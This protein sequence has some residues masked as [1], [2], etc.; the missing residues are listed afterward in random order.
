MHLPLKSST[1]KQKS[2]FEL[3]EDSFSFLFFFFFLEDLSIFFSLFLLGSLRL[4]GHKGRENDLSLSLSIFSSFKCQSLLMT[5]SIQPHYNIAMGQSSLQLVILV[6]AKFSKYPLFWG[7]LAGHSWSTIV[8]LLWPLITHL[9]QL[10]LMPNC[11]LTS[12]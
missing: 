6:L 7:S 10:R 11:P 3:Q 5:T 9:I 1:T 12:S 8:A 4:Q 2:D